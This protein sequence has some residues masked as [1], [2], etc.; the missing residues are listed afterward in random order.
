MK[1][2]F[3]SL[4]TATFAWKFSKMECLKLSHNA[5]SP[6]EFLAIKSWIFD[7]KVRTLFYDYNKVDE[8]E[9]YQ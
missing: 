7:A 3:A 6:E 2:D 1:I 8:N 9:F 5:F 4:K